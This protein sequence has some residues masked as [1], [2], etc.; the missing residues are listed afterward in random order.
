M[1]KKILITILLL[2]GVFLHYKSQDTSLKDKKLSASLKDQVAEEASDDDLSVDTKSSHDGQFLNKKN[3]KQL[4]KLGEVFN[5]FNTTLSK[6]ELKKMKEDRAKY[7]LKE[8]LKEK[9]Q[10]LEKA[11]Y[12]KNYS[13]NDLKRLQ[14][15]IVSLKRK[16]NLEVENIEKWD[17]KFVY[18][19]I[20]NDN[21]TLSEINQMKNLSEHGL[22]QDEI[23]YIK[24]H[25]QTAEF[26]QRLNA[27]KDSNETVRKTASV[28]PKE[29]DEFNDEEKQTASLE[30]KLIEMDYNQDEKDEM[31]YGF[32]QNN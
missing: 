21:Y 16:L 13:V 6:D 4:D 22:S 27:F 11:Y 19:L 17:P 1:N 10:E 8:A 24:E 20:I 23:E 32:N 9:T 14:S 2:G 30:D 29:K 12:A 5:E 25:I 18:Y 15:E 31:T 28:Q 26:N 3:A 7:D